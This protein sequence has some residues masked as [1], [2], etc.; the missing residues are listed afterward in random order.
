MKVKD[1]TVGGVFVALY[2]VL[3]YVFSSDIKQMQ[4]I[5]I[6]IKIWIIAYY[7]YYVDIRNKIAF[8]LA[9]IFISLIL[10]PV[11]IVVTYNIPS[12]V[13]GMVLSS[14][15]KWNRPF[16]GWSLYVIV[17][18]LFLGYEAILYQ[19]FWGVDI[20]SVCREISSSI[21]ASSVQI[22][23]YIRILT[24]LIILLNS[25]ISA[26]ITFFLANKLIDKYDMNM[27]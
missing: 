25:M 9:V 19:F 26:S 22:S 4:T 17:N 15:I 8:G 11:S 16:V 3:C 12:I 5:I 7:A 1:V 21:Q 27:F 2:M 24:I 23:F 18:T 13:L 20:V 14:I 10:F 6:M